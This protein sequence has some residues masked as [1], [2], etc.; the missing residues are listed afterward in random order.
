MLIK[1]K[2]IIIIIAIAFI[3]IAFFMHLATFCHAKHD[4]ININDPFIK[5]IP[6]VI[7]LFTTI[8]STRQEAQ[9]VKNIA[10][11]L[12]NTL[13]FTDFF[14]IISQT[15]CLSTESQKNITSKNINFQQFFSSGAELLITGGIKTNGGIIEAELR[16]FDTYKKKQLIGKKYKGW[17]KDK[18]KIIYRF[19]NE[20]I[21]NLTGTKGIFGSKIAFVSTGSGNKEI[22]FCGFD[23]FNPTK[24][25]NTKAITI[26]PSWSSDTKWIAYTSYKN[27]KPD[28][29]IKNIFNRK[30]YVI[31]QK[32]I[33]ITPAWIPVPFKFTM[34]ATLSFSGDHEI[35]ILTGKGK[36]IKRLTEKTGIDISPTWSPDGKKIAFVSK[37]SGTPQI[38]IKNIN[39]KG[40]KRLT[41]NGRYNTQPSWSPKGD[42]I[43]YSSLA[44]NQINI[45]VIDIYGKNLFQLTSNSGDNE[46]PSWSPDGNFIG[47]SSTRKGKSKIYVMTAKGKSQRPIVE[48]TGEQ[49]DPSWSPY[50]YF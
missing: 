35:Y 31:A 17:I 37:R 36:I 10:D 20:V 16:L 22:Y 34:A 39:G 32:G 19:C 23:G 48:L 18:R 11:I 6:I 47:F 24:F 38:Y 3:A 28:I 30:K 2:R 21:Y 14:K 49:S 33:N 50:I 45:F 42:K 9:S 44:N 8:C 7:P 15:A 25:T 43:A 27:G 4:Y 5:K 1:R 40:V 13:E 46:S 26:S 29:F 41:Y 12:K